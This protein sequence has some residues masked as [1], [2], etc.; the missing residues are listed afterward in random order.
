MRLPVWGHQGTL[1][2]YGLDRPKQA[3]RRVEQRAPV[4]AGQGP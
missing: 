1:T 3:A 4:Q 2:L